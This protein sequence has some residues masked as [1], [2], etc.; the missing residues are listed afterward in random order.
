[1]YSRYWLVKALRCYM[2]LFLCGILK[3]MLPAEQLQK[4]TAVTRCLVMRMQLVI[5]L[6][7]AST[8]VSVTMTTSETVCSACPSTRVKSTMAAAH[9]TQPPVAMWVPIR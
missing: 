5:T 6:D 9:L 4:S 1:M 8:S 3:S 7:W 2:A